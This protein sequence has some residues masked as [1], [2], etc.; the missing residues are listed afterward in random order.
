MHLVTTRVYIADVLTAEGDGYRGVWL[1]K[2]DALIGVNLREAQIVQKDFQAR[3]ATI[4]LPPPEVLQSRVD[5]ERTRTWEVRKT[6]WI[7]WGGDPDSLRD[8]VMRQGQRLVAAA[9]GSREN[10]AQARTAAE[11]ILRGFYEEVGWQVRIVWRDRVARQSRH[12][13]PMSVTAAP[14]PA[15]P[16]PI[17]PTPW[18][19]EAALPSPR[20][21]MRR[22]AIVNE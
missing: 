8:T 12:A 10:L 18:P 14:W 9:A 19:P 11:S 6:T 17:R 2:G 7:P 16:L 5:H 3:R 1:I 20:L 13:P 15:P 22:G 4:G 21:T